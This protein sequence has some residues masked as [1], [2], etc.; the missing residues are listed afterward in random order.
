MNTPVALTVIPR[1]RQ[2]EGEMPSSGTGRKDIEHQEQETE[3]RQRMAD[4]SHVTEV[5]VQ[6]N[7]KQDIQPY[8]NHSV[9]AHQETQ[10]KKALSSPQGIH[11]L[12]GSTG[13]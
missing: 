5:Q 13:L 10:M 1:E 11:N 4:R 2:L 3:V 7:S 6:S 9:Y 12:V 8:S